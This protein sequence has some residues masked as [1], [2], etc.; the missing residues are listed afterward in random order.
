ME[1]EMGSC[2]DYRSSSV[3][4][5]VQ[6][7]LRHGLVFRKRTLLLVN[8]GVQS[9]LEVTPAPSKLIHLTNSFDVDSPTKTQFWGLGF[10]NSSG[11]HTCNFLCSLGPL[12][13]S[14]G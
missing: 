2:R 3:I 14:R 13:D 9:L 5:A 4:K 10:G 8:E 7:I 12:G 11:L 6:H 1:K